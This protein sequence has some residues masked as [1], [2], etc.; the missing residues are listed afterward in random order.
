M[1]ALLYGTRMTYACIL[2]KG[3]MSGQGYILCSLSAISTVNPAIISS[4]HSILANVGKSI[5]PYS[6]HSD[7]MQIDA[8]HTS[9]PVYQ[10]QAAT[11]CLP[12][13]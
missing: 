13:S 10:T 5:R 2:V 6:S 4:P 1:R 9:H 7:S 12:A 11:A 3:K 8:Q